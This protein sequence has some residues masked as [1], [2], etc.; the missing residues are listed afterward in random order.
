MTTTTENSI[1]V[2]LERLHAQ[3]K[4]R[5]LYTIIFIGA[6]VFVITSGVIF[7]EEQNAG[8]LSRG[9]DQFWDFPTDLFSGA[10]ASGWDWFGL[11]GI[12]TPEL[13][14]TIN[15]ALFSTALGF[16]CAVFLSL[17]ASTNLISNGWVVSL[18]RRTLD[19]LRSFPELVIAIALLF[20][21][22]KGELPALIAIWL[23]TVGALGKLFSE[24]VE[25]CDMK[26]VEGLQSAGA[27]WWQ[28]VRFGVLPQVLPLFFSYGILRLEINVRAS[29]ILGFVG[30][31]GIGEALKTN[32]SWSYEPDIMAIMALLVI[33]ITTLDYLSTYVRNKLIGG[34]QL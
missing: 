1:D 19:V 25:N 5:A 6:I 23:H 16:I 7:A 32:I 11:V 2:Y 13:F 22:G 3:A 29:T 33:T 21:M 12:Y 4:T 30:A 34:I 15:L 31:G 27:G 24:A 10:W 28:R 20:L 14:R 26:P 8:S 17:F 18:A 9:L